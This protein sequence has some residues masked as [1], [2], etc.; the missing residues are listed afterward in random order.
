MYR[1]QSATLEVQILDPVADQSR[2]GPRYCTGGYIFQ[3][4]DARHGEL[5][6]G[7][8]FPES[9]NWFD[10]QGIP[11][12]FH[13]G[14]LRDPA[15]PGP[16]ALIPGIGLCHLPERRVIEYCSWEVAQSARAIS[17]RASQSFQS[18]ALTIERTVR[19]SGRTIR[20]STRLTNTGQRMIG[21][22]W[23][24]H[25]FYP[26]PEGDELCRLSIPFELRGSDAYTIAESGFLARS[27]WPWAEGHFQ[28]LEHQAAGPFSIQQ[29]HPALGLV[30]ATCSYAPAFFPVWG[31]Q[32]T[33]SWEPYLERSTVPGQS[34]EWWI[35][36][37]F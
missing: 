21:I 31:N 8:T 15:E 19:L 26:H 25:P 5:M 18:Y 17:F 28:P 24:P 22:R 1:L 23:Y 3:V 4:V 20:S 7:P 2:F 9:F 11:D 36:Y 37:D 29:R 35:D 33:F 12:A 27:G 10:G 6:S 34:A 16:E 13:L 14:A 32:H 30:G